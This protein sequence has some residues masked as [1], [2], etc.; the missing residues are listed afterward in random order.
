M[1]LISGESRVDFGLL[2][3][4]IIKR[5]NNMFRPMKICYV[6]PSEDVPSN[7]AGAIHTFEIAKNLVSEGHEVHIVAKFTG[8]EKEEKIEGVNIHRV[9]STKKRIFG[10]PSTLVNS[11]R[12]TSDI[13]KKYD[14]EIIHERMTLPGGVGAITSKLF[15]IPCLLEVNGPV[16]E[17]HIALGNIPNH[18]HRR[19]LKWWRS[20]VLPIYGAYYVQTRSLREIMMDWGLSDK[21]VHVIPNGVDINRFH[22]DING[23][24]ILHKYQLD[25]KNIVTFIGTSREW[26]GVTLLISSIPKILQ[27]Y[28]DTK[29]MIIGTG[30]EQPAIEKMVSDLNLQRDVLLLGTVPYRDIP[31]FISASTICVAPFQPSKLDTMKK[32]G[33][34]FSPIKLFEYMA[35]GKPIIT[36]R[37]GEVNNLFED[38][39]DAYLIEPRKQEL[40]DAAIHLLGDEQMRDQLGK[41]A[42]EKV[43]EYTWENTTSGV[44]GAYQTL[45]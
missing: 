6:A 4:N 10:Y 26:H 20:Q 28:P 38:R 22:P 33:L 1:S 21:K 37:V 31:K 32:Y 2:I 18:S 42:R 11:V 3:T 39:K 17:E 35:C 5:M 19:I 24:E 36:T 9:Y 43:K 40:A 16:L 8:G 44:M 7:Y 29:F 14:I 15:N 12:I 41:M 27:E 13:I 23:M 45:F 34:Y 25:G 30:P